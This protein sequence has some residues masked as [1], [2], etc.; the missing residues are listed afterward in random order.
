MNTITMI[1]LAYVLTLA[2]VSLDLIGWLRP[3][4]TKGEKVFMFIAINVLPMLII[5]VYYITREKRY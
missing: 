1:G 5:P 2:A 4:A 3:D